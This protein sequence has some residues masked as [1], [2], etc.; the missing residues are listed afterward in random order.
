MNF[1]TL[2]ISAVLSIA[3]SSAASASPFSAPRAPPSAAACGCSAG[4]C[5]CEWML[6]CRLSDRA[7]EYFRVPLPLRTPRLP[8]IQ[9]PF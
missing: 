5:T 9:V 8:F 7:V 4:Q 6:E 1:K 2:I 3:A